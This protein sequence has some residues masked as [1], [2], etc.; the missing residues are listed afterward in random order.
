V[1][2]T[3]APLPLDESAGD[4]PPPTRL[5]FEVPGEPQPQGSAKAF[6]HRHTGR[7]MVT[8]DNARLRPWR[9]EVSWHARQALLGGGPLSGPVKV[10]VEFRFSRPGGHFGKRGLR[11]AAPREHVVRPDLD[12]LV[13]A[14][15]DSLS[16]AGIWR[17]DAQVVETRARKRYHERAG[18]AIE[19]T[20]VEMIRTVRGQVG[21]SDVK[22]AG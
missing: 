4:A 16:D 3:T 11:P 17:D 10:T 6:R 22:E 8:S 19:I 9:D 18:A 14:V 15:L 13:R 20:P 5:T 21:V 7:V 1:T 12:K 2:A